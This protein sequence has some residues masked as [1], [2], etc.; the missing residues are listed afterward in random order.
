MFTAFHKDKKPSRKACE[1]QK[2]RFEESRKRF[3]CL[4][5]PVTSS[6]IHTSGIFCQIF[7]TFSDILL[8]ILQNLVY[9]FKYPTNANSPAIKCTNYLLFIMCMYIFMK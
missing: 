1:S 4:L 8:N 2:T 3:V 5:V 9:I 6:I 7:G